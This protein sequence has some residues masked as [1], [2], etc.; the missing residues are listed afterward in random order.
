MSFKPVTLEGEFVRLEPVGEEHAEGLRSAVADGELWRLFY[1]IVPSP[2]QIDPFLRDAGRAHTAGDGL[3]FAT[4]DRATGTVAGSTRFLHSNLGFRRSE[5]G[6]TFLGATWQRTPINTEAKRLMLA[7][8]F[9]T[10]GLNRVEFLTDFF[11]TRSRRAILRLGA[12]EEGLLRSHMQMPDG[13]VRDSVLFSII[14]T[15]WPGV[16]Q[17]LDALLGSHRPT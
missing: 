8:A 4:I 10:L 12:K 11:N 16:R 5:I 14:R 6:F 1:T 17:H 9:D 7:H 3:T 2:D 13:R 15:E